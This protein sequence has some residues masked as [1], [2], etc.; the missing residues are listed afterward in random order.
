MN[1]LEFKFNRIQGIATISDNYASTI[2]YCARTCY[3]VED[4][5]AHDTWG[6]YIGARLKS[7]HESVIEHNAL[8]MLFETTDDADLE[9]LDVIQ[10]VIA[11]SNNLV[12]THRDHIGEHDVLI[13]TGNI[14]M[15]RDVI[16]RSIDKNCMIHAIIYKVFKN[17]LSTSGDL[18][19]HDLDTPITEVRELYMKLKVQEEFNPI[20][21][22]KID[23]GD[24]RIGLELVNLD[25]VEDIIKDF[26][27][28]EDV[29]RRNSLMFGSVTYRVRNPRIISQQDSRHR[30]QAKSQKSQRYVNESDAT[31]QSGYYVPEVVDAEQLFEVE[32]NGDIIKLTYDEYMKFSF[33]M[34]EAIQQQ[35][36]LKNETARFVLTNSTYTEYCITKPFYTL[37]HYFFERCADAAQY[38]IRIVAKALLNRLKE[39]QVSQE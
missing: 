36:G 12:V 23:T 7:R 35:A 19:L 6:K 14:K 29:I 17:L 11:E 39:D 9:L 1:K 13:A 22:T 10:I 25:S 3:N 15:F 5:M 38:E 28:Y 27:E 18:F 26:P 33:R 2:E 30:I 8:T 24:D 37:S 16:K 34:Y 20:T 32:L 31:K 21:L 4:K